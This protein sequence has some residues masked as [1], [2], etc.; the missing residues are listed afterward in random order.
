MLLCRWSR[1]LSVNKLSQTI[2]FG[3]LADRQYGDA[4][5]ALGA[6]ASSG[7][8]VSYSSSD[9]GVATVVGNT[10]TIHGPGRRR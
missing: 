2:T 5:F 10:V 4:P 7:L 6:T 8:T 3:A 9:V 1:P